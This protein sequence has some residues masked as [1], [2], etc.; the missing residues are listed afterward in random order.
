MENLFNKLTDQP[1][2][3]RRLSVLMRNLQPHYTERL[4]VKR[5]ATVRELTVLCAEIEENRAKIARFKPPPSSRYGSLLEPA[6]AYKHCQTPKINSCDYEEQSQC[7]TYQLCEVT[8][9]RIVTKDSKNVECLNCQ[10]LGRWSKDCVNPKTRRNCKNCGQKW[11]TS[12]TAVRNET[13]VN[14]VECCDRRLY[15]EGNDVAKEC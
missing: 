13:T 15:E 9:K 8:G 7:E 11:P 3:N 2:E 6:L 10:Q 4:C 12:T 5:I 1:L 14:E